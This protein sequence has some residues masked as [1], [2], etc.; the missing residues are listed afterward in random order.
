M[1]LTNT[2]I[3]AL[4]SLDMLRLLIEWIIHLQAFQV[5]GEVAGCLDAESWVE[6]GR[7]GCHASRP[8]PTSTALPRWADFDSHIERLKL[9]EFVFPQDN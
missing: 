6:A 5:H 1:I 4:R 2:A 8:T 3:P 7:V 9:G